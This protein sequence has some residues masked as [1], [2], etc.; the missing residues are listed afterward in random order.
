MA[1]PAVSG[2]EGY[3]EVAPELFEREQSIPFVSDHYAV[4]HKLTTRGAQFDV[5]IL[6]AVWMISTRNRGGRRC[7][8]LR[9]WSSRRA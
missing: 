9:A 8:G 6:T 1:S 2:T 5:V 7:R 3:A 4:L